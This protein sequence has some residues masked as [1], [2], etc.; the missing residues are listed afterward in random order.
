MSRR[1]CRAMAWTVGEAAELA[2]V[3]V[4]TLHHYDEIGL[5]EPSDRSEAGYRLYT[6]DDLERLQQIL[7]FR[8]LGFALPEI[9]AI[10][11]D[12]GVRPRRGAHRRSATSSPRRPAAP[13]GHR[14][15]RP[16]TD[17]DGR[18]DSDDEG[19]GVEDVRRA[20]RRL[21]PRRV[22]GRG[23]GALGRDRRLQAVRRAHEALQEGRLGADQGRDGRATT[24]RSSR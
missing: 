24:P 22:R 8:E 19:R 14:R 16:A 21:R 17:G 3:S 18:R 4:R 11:L 9:R 1:R 23:P 12:P 5:L 6:V 15:D 7:L 10:V 13:S 20:V 2:K